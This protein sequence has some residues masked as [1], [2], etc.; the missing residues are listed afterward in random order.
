MEPTAYERRIT[1][2]EHLV[3]AL[4]YI[5]IGVVSVVSTVFLPL[6]NSTLTMDLCFPTNAAG[7]VVFIVSKLSVALINILIFYCFLKQAVVNVKD[8]DSYKEA[9]HLMEQTTKRSTFKP[10]SPGHYKAVVWGSKGTTLLV[11]SFLSVIA[12]GSAVLN[13]NLNVFLASV[14]TVLL[15]VVFGFIQ[16]RRDEEYWTSEFLA[17]ARREAS[18]EEERLKNDQNQSILINESIGF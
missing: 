1:T 17:Y 12:F 3:N 16:M 18:K 15:G 14:F 7:W 6:V 10:R 8:T 13:F 9:L 4:Y 2:K 5:I 11:S